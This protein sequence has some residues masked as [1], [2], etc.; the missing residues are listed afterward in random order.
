M[1]PTLHAQA[2]GPASAVGVAWAWALFVQCERVPTRITTHCVSGKRWPCV[3]SASGSEPF[4]RAR[5]RRDAAKTKKKSRDG[6]DATFPF[7]FHFLLFLYCLRSAVQIYRLLQ[8]S[9]L[10]AVM[11][12]AIAGLLLLSILSMPAV[13]R[14]AAGHCTWVDVTDSVPEPSWGCD[15][16]CDP[17]RDPGRDP[18]CDPGCDPG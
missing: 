8:C 18:G 11:A 2:V 10:S 13:T 16:G 14:H 4:A 6:Y 15:P 5:R 17:G 12:A 7:F 3:G 9:I 1:V